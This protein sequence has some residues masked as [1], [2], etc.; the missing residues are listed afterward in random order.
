MKTRLVAI[1]ICLSIFN[2][3][4]SQKGFKNN[5]AKVIVNSGGIINI[6][7]G[8]SADFINATSGSTH[9]RI[10]LDGKIKLEGDWA[11]N[12][13]SGSV[14]IN[15]DTDGE[16]QFKGTN[17]HAVSGNQTDYE[18]LTLN[19][20][21]NVTLSTAASAN[22]DLVLTNGLL[23]LG[24][25]N[26]TLGS[27]SAIS[28]TP[29][30]S[31]MV[32]ANSTGEL[33]KTFTGTGSFTYPIG[34]NTSTVEYS[35]ITLNFA[36]GTFGGSAYAGARV[37]N[38]KH[39]NN[40]STTGYINR[41]WSLSQSNI[42]A[43]S[44]ALTST[45]TTAD[46]FG[47]ETSLFSG[48]YSTPYWVKL[49]AVNAG[50]NQL[51]GTV[52]DF[53]PITAGDQAMF[54]TSTITIAE[55]ITNVACYGNNTGAINVTVSGGY[56]TY[57]YNWSGTGVVASQEDQTGL[58]AG[59]YNLTV[60]DQNGCTQTDVFS[61]SQPAATL[62]LSTTQTDISC[63]GNSTGAVD[64]TVTGGTPSY[65]Y[66]WSSGATSQDLSSIVAG[67][68]LVTVTDANSCTATTSATIT[69]PVS[70]LSVAVTSQTNVSCFGGNNGAINITASGGTVGTGYTYNWG[71]GVTT[72]DRTSL[73]AGTY[74]VTVTDANS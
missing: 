31:N 29:T 18:K 64:L 68:Y 54:C 33:R 23:V 73:I 44:C 63:Y 17:V 6:T 48:Y 42:S 46:I 67:T 43:F 8:T 45:Y 12:A 51:I 14:F 25:N 69:Q 59:T 47:T 27:S 24:T 39:P 21:G 49:A 22:G 38:A 53:N 71:S 56:G 30:S 5:G 65:S 19:T 16:V 7:G 15:V 9:G 13:T 60:T 61:I 62:T 11:N 37:T 35:P 57:T 72:E 66:N 34:D 20:T 41:Y 10:D 58:T 55:S 50:A 36:S 74:T 2:I 28:G 3:A 52:S 1:L 40:A 70:A 26:L 4:Y 32:V